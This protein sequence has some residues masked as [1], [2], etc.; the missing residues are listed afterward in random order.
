MVPI[1]NAILF[2]LF[3]ALDKL[4]K[5]YVCYDFYCKA[6]KLLSSKDFCAN[7]ERL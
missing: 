7:Y 4:F 6:V 5:C 1:I 2:V 3:Y